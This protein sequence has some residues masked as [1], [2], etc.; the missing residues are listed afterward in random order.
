MGLL[1]QL[2]AQC[3]QVRP[4]ERGA[5]SEAGWG[6]GAHASKGVQRSA[7]A[8]PPACYV[9]QHA[10]QAKRGSAAFGADFMP[11]IVSTPH[12]HNLPMQEQRAELTLV[13]AALA[14]V[15]VQAA[16][17]WAILSAAVHQAQ[18]QKQR[19]E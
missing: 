8:L 10:K 9:V 3:M 17:I 16:C 14:L 6:P 7:A 12:A 5:Q 1:E 19:Q 11:C 15:G 2:P 18:V 4:A 13:R